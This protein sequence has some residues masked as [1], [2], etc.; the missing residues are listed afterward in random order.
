MGVAW[1]FDGE[2]ANP[3]LFKGAD[4][5]YQPKILGPAG[6]HVGPHYTLAYDQESRDWSIEDVGDAGSDEGTDEDFM[7]LRTGHPRPESA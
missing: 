4:G 1:W 3:Y 2:A 7:A 6:L 5:S